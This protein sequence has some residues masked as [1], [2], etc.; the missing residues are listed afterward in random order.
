MKTWY[1]HTIGFYSVVEYKTMKL[2]GKSIALER[3]KTHVLFP[4]QT[5]AWFVCVVGCGE[6]LKCYKRDQDINDKNR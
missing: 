6:I 3:Q 2:A 4:M 5:L 1:I